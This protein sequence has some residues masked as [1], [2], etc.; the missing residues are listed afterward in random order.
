M[1]KKTKTILLILLFIS[2]GV[3]FLF[4]PVKDYF[5]QVREY[6][7]DLGWAG[8][9]VVV[10]A[11]AALTIAM[12]PGSALTLGIGT[13]YGLGVGTV[14]VVAGSN[15]GALGAFFLARSVL[16]KEVRGWADRYPKFQNL[17]AAIGKQGFRIVL[18]TRLSPLFPFTFINYGL[19]LTGVRPGTYVLAN[20]LG[21]LPGTFMYVYI[22]SLAGLALSET[23]NNLHFALQALGFAATVAVTILITRTAKRA[24][25]QAQT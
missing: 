24:L 1:S 22:G 19:G 5:E 8:P 18:L 13:L 17:D 12:I 9:V 6:V 23:Q 21:M 4:L 11:Y 15:L 3:S 2:V 10:L 25:A 7:R 20:V 16:R 14:I